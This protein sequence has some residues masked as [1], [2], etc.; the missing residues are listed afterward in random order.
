MRMIYC[1]FLLL[2]ACAPHAVR[3]DGHLRPINTPAVHDASGA[4][5]TSVPGHTAPRLP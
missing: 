4:P 2:P 3:C 1:L 5:A